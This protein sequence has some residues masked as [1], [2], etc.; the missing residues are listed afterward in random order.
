MMIHEAH[1]E[2]FSVKRRLIALTDWSKYHAWPPLGGL[3]HLVF[4]A[5]QNGFYNV[6]RR[7]NKRILIDECAFFD[8]IDQQ[9]QGGK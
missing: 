9:Q 5:K 1:S 2:D 6:I 8:W 4:H 3:R 7:V